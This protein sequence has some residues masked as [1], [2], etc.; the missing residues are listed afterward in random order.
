MELVCSLWLVHMYVC[1]K[2]VEK[3]SVHKSSEEL[4][5]RPKTGTEWSGK[6]DKLSSGAPCRKAMQVYNGKKTSVC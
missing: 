4:R 6:Y 1:C 3:A 2:H 5:Y